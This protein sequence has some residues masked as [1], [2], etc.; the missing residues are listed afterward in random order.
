[1]RPR[2][3]KSK[4]MKDLNIVSQTA[5]QFSASPVAAK[6]CCSGHSGRGG[7]SCEDIEDMEEARVM[8]EKLLEDLLIKIV[9]YTFI[10][11]HAQ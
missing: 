6:E 5:S 2:N 4:K 11:M 3:R 7:H 9:L 8:I 10:H 1:M